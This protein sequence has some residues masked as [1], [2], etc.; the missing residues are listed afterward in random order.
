MDLGAFVLLVVFQ[1]LSFVTKHKANQGECQ[2]R[3][4]LPLP[5]ALWHTQG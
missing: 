1:Y 5:V 3:R 4:S 2:G